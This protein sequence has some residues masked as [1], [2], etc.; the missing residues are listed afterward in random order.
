[1][2]H[3]LLCS[4]F[5]RT[6]PMHLSWALFQIG[7]GSFFETCHPGRGRDDHYWSPPVVT[8]RPATAT[9]DL[10]HHGLRLGA[11]PQGAAHFTTGVNSKSS[12]PADNCC[13]SRRAQP[14][15]P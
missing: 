5:S 13:K 4:R 10:N 15:K 6:Y 12:V 8:S 1:M 2:D 14:A 3:L 9:F 7:E 11:V